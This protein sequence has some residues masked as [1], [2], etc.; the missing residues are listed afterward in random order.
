MN[1]DSREEDNHNVTLSAAEKHKLLRLKADKMYRRNAER[2]QLQYSKA[3]RKKIH[4]FLAGNFVSVKI[5]RIDTT[6]TDLHRVACVVVVVLGK[7]YHFYRL[8]YVL[9]VI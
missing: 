6:S 3:K 9:F 5:P 8:R 2:M 1:Q 7:E 4:T